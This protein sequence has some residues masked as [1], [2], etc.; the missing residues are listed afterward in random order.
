MISRAHLEAQK[1]LYIQGQAQAIAQLEG[2]DKQRVQTIGQINMFMGS[3]DAIEG[4]LKLLNELEAAQAELA[5]NNEEE[6]NA[7]AFAAD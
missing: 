3:I 7:T 6:D 5:E 2:L 4:L 1:G